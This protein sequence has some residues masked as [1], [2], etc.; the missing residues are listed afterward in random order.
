MGFWE[1]PGSSF[2]IRLEPWGALVFQEDTLKIEL[3]KKSKLRWRGEVELIS[4]MVL[5]LSFEPGSDVLLLEFIPPPDLPEKD[6]WS[7][8]RRFTAQR[9]AKQLEPEP[10]EAVATAAAALLEPAPEPAPEAAVVD[11]PGA[12]EEELAVMAAAPREV[13]G[14]WSL[15][16]TCQH[17]DSYIMYM[18]CNP[19]SLFFFTY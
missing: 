6:Q 4:G 8:P 9:R 1:Y 11:S 2:E 10:V 13:L 5:N 17:C 15:R 7:G 3:M 19:S 12:D 18:L 14:K 16:S